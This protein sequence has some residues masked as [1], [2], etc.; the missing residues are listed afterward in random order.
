MIIKSLELNNFRNYE[1][2]VFEFLDGVNIIYGRNAQGKTN[3]VE[4]VF[5]LCTGYSPRAVYDKQ[6][7]L[8]G[9]SFAKISGC[10]ESLYGKVSVELGFHEPGGKRIKINGVE[11]LKMGELMGN[12][13]SVFFNPDELKLIKESPDDRRRFLDISLSQMDKKYYYALARYKKIL[14]QRNKLLKDEDTELI[15]ETL[16]IWDMQLA[17]VGAKIIRSRMDYITFLSPFAAEAHSYLTDGE[18]QL[19]VR[20]ASDYS[21]GEEEI[22]ADFRSKLKERLE[23]DIALGYTS[24]GPHRDDLKLK[25]NGKEVK[26]FGSQGQQRTTA[27]SLKLAET[28][29]FKA[30]FKEYPVLILDD[31]LSE[32]D[33]DRKKRL[34]KK[35][36][37]L[38]TLITLTEIDESFSE[39]GAYKCFEINGGRIIKTI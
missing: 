2:E 4:A 38:Q 13:N 24:V 37:N 3:S 27:L 32:L 18:E 22:A 7:I 25:I 36:S 1:H 34:L 23:K 33:S 29:I 9:E 14:Y 31:A 39:I 19:E 6:V 20:S 11:T 12:I 21:G 5:Y 30:N 16:P 15:R 35:I 17:A 8:Q 26:T 10:A 28:E